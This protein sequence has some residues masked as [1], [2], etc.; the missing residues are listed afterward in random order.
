MS[1]ID[2]TF[3]TGSKQLEL[4]L[5][6]GVDKTELTR[7]GLDA[8]AP[9]YVGFLDTTPKLREPG[10]TR[11]VY[12]KLQEFIQ[13]KADKERRIIIYRLG[14]SNQTLQIFVESPMFTQFFGKWDARS[15]NHEQKFYYKQYKPKTL[16][17]GTQ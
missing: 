16:E 1:G 9:V 10:E 6:L 15:A 8:N 11:S 12:K 4:M 13:E 7:L 2:A 17:S 5:A 3:E 14:T